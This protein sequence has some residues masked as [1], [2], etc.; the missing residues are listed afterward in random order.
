MINMKIL[1]NCGGELQHAIKCRCVDP[2]STED[3]INSVEDIIARKIIGKTW[4][5]N[6]LESQ[7]IPKI[8]RKDKKPVLKCHICGRPSHLANTY[9]NKTKINEV[10][11]LEDVQCAEEKEES[12]QDSAFSTYTPGK[13]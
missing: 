2:C 4:F 10:E 6:L 7:M 5:K 3:Y 13:D 11:V 9:I 1:R 8:S 12:D